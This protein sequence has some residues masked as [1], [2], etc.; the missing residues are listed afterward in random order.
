M[1]AI[2]FYCI[3]RD[4]SFRLY[5]VSLNKDSEPLNPPEQSLKCKKWVSFF[6]N[7]TV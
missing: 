3:W 5:N 4:K 7:N 6:I 2:G 1:T